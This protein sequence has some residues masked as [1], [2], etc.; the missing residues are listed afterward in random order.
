MHTRIA[1]IQSYLRHNDHSL[2]VRRILDA[3]LDTA[4]G[5]LLQEAIRV[6]QS[7]RQYKQGELPAS[8]FESAQQLL[9]K[10]NTVTERFAYQSTR[11]VTARDISKTYGSGNFSLQPISI[12]INTG[13]VLGVVG[14]NGNGKTT[15][16]RCMA[17]QLALDGG[18]LEF[19]LLEH[20]D[21]YDIKH[22]LAFIPQRIPR[23]YGLLKDNLHFA[24]AISGITGEENRI[25]VDFMLE[26]LDLTPYA[27]LTWTQISSGYRTRFE[28]ARILLQKPRLLILDEPLANLDINAQQSILTDLRFMAKSVHNPMGILLSSQQLHEVEKIADTV[29]LIKNGSCLF[30]TG[31]Q[32]KTAAAFVIELETT[33]NREA[34]LNILNGNGELQF[35]GGFYTITSK[36]LQAQQILTKLVTGNIPITYFRD[37]THSTKRFI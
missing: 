20:P 33:A 29:L 21:H 37:I 5:A 7:Y 23:W 3:S 17:G 12:Q 6:S 26:R 24:A 9:N 19:P 25:M 36:E 14:E 16:L 34:L 28:I 1:E 30:R 11:L 18:N 8:F 35:N 2:A 22:H 10:I 15:L 31:E 13:D 4:D 32:E 27:H